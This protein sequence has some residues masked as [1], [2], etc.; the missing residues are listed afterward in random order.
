MA[1]F[2]ESNIYSYECEICKTK[3]FKSIELECEEVAY[4]YEI[5]DNK[6]EHNHDYNDG[7]TFLICENDHE[8]MQPFIASCDCGW[9]SLD[10]EKYSRETFLKGNVKR[11]IF[12]DS[13][14]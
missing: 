11:T 7:T 14:D 13:D 12:S 3:K 6:N 1:K 2:Y 8:T 5:D 10:Q 9:N 4:N